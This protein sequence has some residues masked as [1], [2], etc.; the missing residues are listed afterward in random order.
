MTYPWG[1]DRRFNDFPTYIKQKFGK[2]IQKL[3]IN[4]GFSCPNRDG[5][6]G[7]GGCIY[8]DNNTFKPGYCE[9]VQPIV[10]QL[11]T[12]MAFFSKKYPQ[13]QYMAY[14]QSYTNTYAPVG[15]LAKLY[16]EALS[17]PNVVGLVVGTRPDCFPEEVAQMLGEI[18]KEYYVTVE[19]GLESTLNRTLD[20]INRCHTWEESVEAI[21]RCKKY[22]IRAGGHLILGLP[23]ETNDDFMHHAREIS[24][25]PLHTL[26][27]HQLQVT[28]NTSL[29][30]K[31]QENPE[32]V[33]QFSFEEYL[34]TVIAFVEVLNP[35]I[36]VERFVSTSPLEK[37]VAPR[38]NRMKNFE[39]VATIEKALKEQNTWQGKLWGI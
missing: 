19:F 36:I 21:L 31:Y 32:Y 25:L 6:K 35:S 38:W 29:F 12:G 1:H 23:G 2:R 15:E 30:K 37:L 5:S 4:V 34:Q 28:K 27:L 17:H 14:F 3:S 39:I 20:E 22:G 33:K 26:K 10:Q 18:S 11:E 9:P 13:M 7:T 24:K 8:C 16:K